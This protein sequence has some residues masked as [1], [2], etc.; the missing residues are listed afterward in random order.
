[1]WHC[2]DI[3]ESRIISIV[4]L[5]I[6]CLC[7]TV[8]TIRILFISLCIQ[9]QR[10]RILNTDS[11]QQVVV[12]DTINERGVER[13]QVLPGDGERPSEIRVDIT[14]ENLIKATAMRPYWSDSQSR[15]TSRTSAST[16]TSADSP[17]LPATTVTS[18]ATT[19]TSGYTRTGFSSA[20][21]T[22]TSGYT[23]T[24]FSAPSKFCGRGVNS[25]TIRICC[26]DRCGNL[27]SGKYR[28]C[29]DCY[30]RKSHACPRCGKPC[31]GKQCEACHLAARRW[32]QH[33]GKS[34]VGRQCRDC[35]YFRP[36]RRCPCCGNFCVGLQCQ[37][38]N[39]KPCH[40]CLIC[41][42]LCSSSHFRCRDCYR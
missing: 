21:T 9:Y 27:C 39:M 10:W 37:N 11:E 8:L 15:E 13:Y 12:H 14:H 26:N 32:C 30:K 3:V 29:E 17:S 42:N 22:V 20:A 25:C 2:P 34:C 19:V 7:A 6:L 38:C 41:G 5:I 16:T 28:Q 23:R 18:A 36:V 35:H 40:P 1:M 4:F 31:L 24:G 33:C